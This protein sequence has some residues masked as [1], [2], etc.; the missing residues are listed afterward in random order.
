MFIHMSNTTADKTAVS[1]RLKEIEK[2]LKNISK[3]FQD[4]KSRTSKTVSGAVSRSDD[5]KIE[6]LRKKMGLKK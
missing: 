3:T 1:K 2:E 6:D 4:I 5:R